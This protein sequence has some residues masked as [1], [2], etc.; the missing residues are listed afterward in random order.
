MK[1]KKYYNYCVKVYAY[2][3]EKSEYFLWFIR[4]FSSKKNYEIWRDGVFHGNDHREIPLRVKLGEPY[5][6]YYEFKPE[7]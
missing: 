1:E 7:F 4:R 5:V 2:S 3:E 6:K